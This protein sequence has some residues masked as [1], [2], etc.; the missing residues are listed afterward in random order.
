MKFLAARNRQKNRI[1]EMVYS[2]FSMINRSHDRRMF[3][4]HARLRGAA[5]SRWF[6]LSIVRWSANKPLTHLLDSANRW[7]FAGE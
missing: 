3:L 2:K 6:Y 5:F 4:E 7:K 1:V